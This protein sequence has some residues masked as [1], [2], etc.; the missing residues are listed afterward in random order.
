MRLLSIILT[1]SLPLLVIG[2]AVPTFPS[3]AAACPS[4]VCSVYKTTLDLGCI[5]GYAAG[6]AACIGASCGTDLSGF[7]AGTSILLATC[8]SAKILPQTTIANTP[9]GSLATS[10]SAGTI[11][12]TQT[13]PATTPPPSTGQNGATT[14]SVAKSSATMYN[15]RFGL[16]GLALVLFMAGVVN[17]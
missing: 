4:N 10:T 12:T 5:C 16:I 11:A 6:M 7:E 2:Q 1:I 15:G 14:S 17:I 13:G 3:C 8:A 9:T